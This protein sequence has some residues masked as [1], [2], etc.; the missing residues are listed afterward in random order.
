MQLPTEL[1]FKQAKASY[2]TKNYPQAKTQFESLIT[3][4]PNKE[5]YYWYAKVCMAQKQY[6]QAIAYFRKSLTVEE[7]DKPINFENIQY[8]L[9]A[10]CDIAIIY[11]RQDQTSQALQY[12]S[13]ARNGDPENA[14]YC[15]VHASICEKQG[16]E[17]R[18]ADIKMRL[19]EDPNNLD[20]LHELAETYT[21][22]RSEH[23]NKEAIQCYQI[24]L[25]LSGHLPLVQLASLHA[26]IG[27]LYKKNKSYDQA[28]AHYHKAIEMQTASTYY[29]QVAVIY[30]ENNQL[31]KAKEAFKELL[32]RQRNMASQ[33][34]DDVDQEL[35][36]V[37]YRY[38]F[39]KDVN[40]AII[41]CHATFAKSP[42][43]PVIHQNLGYFYHIK[44]EL[45]LAI[46]HSC[47]AIKAT[48]IKQEASTNA[49]YNNLFEILLNLKS[50][51]PLLKLDMTLVAN[52][53]LQ[54]THKRKISALMLLLD[55][56]HVLGN[57]FLQ[58]CKDKDLIYTIIKAIP[59][60]RKIY[61]TRA[62]KTKTDPL[63]KICHLQRKNKSSFSESTLTRMEKELEALCAYDVFLAISAKKMPVED[64]F[65]AM[66]DMLYT[67]WLSS[68]DPV[69]VGHI[70]RQFYISAHEVPKYDVFI[71]SLTPKDLLAAILASDALYTKLPTS[72]NT[73]LLS[74]LNYDSILGKKFVK[75]ACKEYLTQIIGSLSEEGDALLLKQSILKQMEGEE[76]VMPQ[77][78]ALCIVFNTTRSFFGG[79]ISKKTDHIQA[80]H[81][82]SKSLESRMMFRLFDKKDHPLQLSEQHIKSVDDCVD[83]FVDLGDEKVNQTLG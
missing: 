51:E 1:L 76:S 57:H 81:K 21:K 58:E 2:D 31:D 62:C 70:I 52:I 3:T 18:C 30:R 5:N 69:K 4:L 46:S 68:Y 28:L 56:E 49:A 6:E 22:M 38:D 17:T 11:N 74:C 35:L 16:Y 67:G 82:E 59:D 9:E 72:K 78:R 75:E 32:K 45:G 50:S 43:S 41:C 73:L 53:I 54:A 44:G 25:D 42:D 27:F 40:T 48:G 24:I 13:H 37:Q 36:L 80:L 20:L 63:F 39:N 61:L 14:R 8:T 79:K 10:Y 77:Y 55:T 83:E 19:K 47:E 66:K 64:K 60:A 15:H 23:W 71:A 26:D 29:H 12:I 65:E 34:P 7:I 33:Y